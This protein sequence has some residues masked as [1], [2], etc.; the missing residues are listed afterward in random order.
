MNSNRVSIRQWSPLPESAPS[1]SDYYQKMVLPSTDV[2]VQY[3]TNHRVCS[4]KTHESK[5]VA[6]EIGWIGKIDYNVIL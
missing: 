2:H 5:H 3:V 1:L 4:P 6:L